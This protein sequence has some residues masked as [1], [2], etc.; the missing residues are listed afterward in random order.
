[1]LLCAVIAHSPHN[2]LVRLSAQIGQLGAEA[3]DVDAVVQ[4]GALVDKLADLDEIVA[5]FWRGEVVVGLVVGEVGGGE[6][7]GPFADFVV[8]EASPDFDV[9]GAGVGVDC[10]AG[11]DVFDDDVLGNDGV[12][13]EN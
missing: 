6:V 11:E 7:E 1:M 8:G 13:E 5:V 3:V 10:C 4:L 2:D 12:A 9:A